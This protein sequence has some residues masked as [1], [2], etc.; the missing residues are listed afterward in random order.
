MASLDPDREGVQESVI[1]AR[2]A[3]I[4]VAPW[5][6]SDETAGCV[7]RVGAIKMGS[8]GSGDMRGSPLLLLS[9]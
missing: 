7:R 4:R 9:V 8:P 3:G 6:G 2:S 5:L 1:A